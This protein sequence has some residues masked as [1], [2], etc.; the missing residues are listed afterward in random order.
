MNN[1]KKKRITYKGEI[2]AKKN[3]EF[4]PELFKLLASKDCLVVLSHG[5]PPYKV[6]LGVP[7]QAAIGEKYI[8]ESKAQRKSDENV[9]SYALV[10]F[11]T[12]K[13]HKVPCKLVIMAHSTMSDPNKDTVSPYFQEI[14]KDPSEVLIECHGA[15]ISRKLDLELSAG[16]NKLSD[17]I[18][19]G[20]LLGS[21]LQR[22]WTLGVQKQAG[23][24][25]ALIFQQDGKISDGQLENPATKTIS[26]I[27]AEEK[28]IH[29]F[30]LEAKPQF[31]KA[32]DGKNKVTDDGF[33]L[34]CALAQAIIRK[35]IN[36]ELK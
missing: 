22:K 23:A 17:I 7:H 19:F 4:N 34:G 9:A 16:K 13:E 15:G 20:K 31:R 5:K 11:T 35:Y 1:E 25:N 10:T 18:G 2:W 8:C 3:K 6:I 29:A 28:K 36:E 33:A 32:C 26:L 14:S 24:N 21:A 27:K 30:H 12:L